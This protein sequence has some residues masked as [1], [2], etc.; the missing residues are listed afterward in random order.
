MTKIG[1]LFVVLSIILINVSF[2]V[3]LANPATPSAEQI[4]QWQKAAEQGDAAAQY[5]L[6]IAY[7][8]GSGVTLNHAEAVKWYSK[9]ANQGNA[10]AQLSLG[11][12]YIKGEGIAKN[13]VESAKWFRKSADQGN[14]TAQ[15]SLGVAY[16]N[17]DGVGRDI[18]TAY[19]WLLLAKSG[20]NQSAPKLLAALD[21]SISTTQQQAAREWAKKWKPVVTPAPSNLPH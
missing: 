7:T 2:N 12:A 11:I 10:K 13:A 5:N 6:G 3:A 15:C 18:S 20:G 16:V 19:G 1:I 17:G 4:Q 9:A 21:K 8:I 14:T